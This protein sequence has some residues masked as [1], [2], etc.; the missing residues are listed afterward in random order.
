[1]IVVISPKTLD[2]ILINSSSSN[3]SNNNSNSNSHSSTDSSFLQ[4]FFQLLVFAFDL[5]DQLVMILQ[6]QS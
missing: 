4:M 5:F 6:A 1:M 3:S 2:V